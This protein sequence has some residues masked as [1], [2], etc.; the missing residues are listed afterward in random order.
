MHRR[1][2]SQRKNFTRKNVKDQS[3]EIGTSKVYGYQKS[4]NRSYY[5][6]NSISWTSVSNNLDLQGII[7]DNEPLPFNN[8]NRVQYSANKHLRNNM[9]DI[10]SVNKS[11]MVKKTHIR[12]FYNPWTTGRSFKDSDKNYKHK[13]SIRVKGTISTMILSSLSK[14]KSKE[15]LFFPHNRPLRSMN[16][17]KK[18]HRSLVSSWDAYATSS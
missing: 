10:Q 2:K 7:T 11:Q 6:N 14:P 5:N 15:S 4:M 17:D 18:A 1:H 12:T 3:W 16:S 13:S 9:S 8:L